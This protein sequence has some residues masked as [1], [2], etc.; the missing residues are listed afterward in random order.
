MQ[1][2]LEESINELAVGA[3]GDAEDS[4]EEGEGISQGSA[5]RASVSNGGTSKDA[6]RPAA[7]GNTQ[8]T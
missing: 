1:S 6:S 7:T 2:A 8:W 4:E 5:A 3:E